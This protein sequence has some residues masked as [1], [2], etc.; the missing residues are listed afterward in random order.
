MGNEVTNIGSCAFSYCG[1]IESIIIP[2]G[3]TTIEANTFMDCTS[4]KNITI[5]CS[6]T[7]IGYNAFANC[8]SLINVYY[9]GKIEDWCKIKFSTISSNPMFKGADLFLLDEQNGWYKVTNI[10]IP[11]S[12]TSIGDYTFYGCWSLESISIPNSITSIGVDSFGWCFTLTDVYYTGT[13]SEWNSII[14]Q[15]GNYFFEDATIHYNYKG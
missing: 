9:T 10:E 2:D 3:V 11:D 15:S 6:V 1:S 8:N 5:P 4:L 7:N 14:I 12:V 13:N